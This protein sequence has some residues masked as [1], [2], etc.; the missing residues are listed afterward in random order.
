MNKFHIELS[1]HTDSKHIHERVIY[2][3]IENVNSFSFQ[4]NPQAP[5][6]SIFPSSHSIYSL[7]STYLF[8]IW[9]W[10]FASQRELI[11]T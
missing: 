2:I 11:S 8:N 7:T 5:P 1:V 4:F 3:E 6:P 10:L 9:L